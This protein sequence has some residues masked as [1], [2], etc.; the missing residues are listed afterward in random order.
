[1]AAQWR[2]YL[3]RTCSIILLVCLPA[4]LQA[5]IPP[6]REYIRLGGRV[7]AIEN[8][9]A[10]ISPTTATLQADASSPTALTITTSS[11]AEWKV[12]AKPD[13]LTADPSNGS[14]VSS[15]SDFTSTLNISAQKNTLS[16]SRSYTLTIE[17]GG[18]VLSVPVTQLGLTAVSLAPQSVN[19][20]SSGASGT[21]QVSGPSGVQWTASASDSAIITALSPSFGTGPSPTT[22]S[23]TV[24]ANLLTMQRPASITIS[25]PNNPQAGTF[26]ITEAGASTLVSLLPTSASPA[27]TG[28]AASFT[29]T[30]DSSIRW[31]AISQSAW[32]TVT[33]PSGTASGTGTVNYSVA[34]NTGTARAGSIK[35]SAA[36]GGPSF[37][38]VPFGI[39][40][41][42]I[43]SVTVDRSSISTKSRDTV[44][45]VNVMAN[46]AWVASATPAAT[47]IHLT[48]ASGDGSTP[49]QPLTFT[50]ENY[51]SGPVRSATITVQA[52]TATATISV[53]QSPAQS[54]AVQPNN[55]VV[56]TGTLFPFSAVVD[57]SVDSAAPVNWSV[58]PPSL[59]QI[60]ATGMFTA[61]AGGPPYPTGTVQA[62]MGTLSA[63]ANVIVIPVAQ[64]PPV[65]S[66]FSQSSTIGTGGMFSASLTASAGYSQIDHLRVRVGTYSVP[67]SADCTVDFFPDT[68][69][70]TNG[71]VWVWT[72][73]SP[74]GIAYIPAAPGT[75]PI[76]GAYCSVN[77]LNTSMTGVTSNGMT[78][79][80][81]VAFTNVF[82]GAKGLYVQ[83][84]G[85]GFSSAN[86]E[87]NE[88]WYTVIG[89]P[90][91][92]SVSP[93]SG[94]GASP[95]FTA[96]FSYAAGASNLQSAD[97]LLNT[98][99]TPAAACW[100]QYR[101]AEN[102]LY[103]MGDDG[104]TWVG[105]F[106][107]N[108]AFTL[109][110]SQCT[111]RG[112]GSSAVVSG[113]NLTLVVPIT[114]KAAFVGAKG[115]WTNATDT[116]GVQAG[117]PQVGMWTAEAPPMTTL[118]TSPTG[119]A[120]VVDEATCTSPCQRQW[121][122]GSSHT[123]S[124]ATQAGASGTQYV[125][126]NWSDAGAALHSITVPATSNTYTA[127]FNTQYYLT[128]AA[129]PTAGGTISPASGWYNAG[130][131]V[132]VS[133]AAN[134]GFDFSGFTADLTGTTTPQTVTMNAPHP[135]TATFTQLFVSVALSPNTVS[136]S[137]NQTQQFT[138]T[139]A[140]TSNTAV[141]WR[142]SP[143]VGSISASGLY[144]APASNATQQMV[145]VTATSVAD[146]T[147]SA[148]STV[149]LT[150]V[151]ISISPTVATLYTSGTQQFTA[152]VTSSSN[153][154]VTWSI[155][156]AVGSVSAAGLYTAPSSIASQQTV[157]VTATSNADPSKTASAT[158]TVKL[159]VSVSL[160]PSSVAYNCMQNPQL[161][162]TVANTGN[163]AV[164]W[165]ASGYPI[166]FS[167]TTANTATLAGYCMA[168][169]NTGTATATSQAD[170][171]KAA[172]AS[173]SLYG[174]TSPYYA[175]GYAGNTV[176]F[177]T[178]AAVSYATASPNI[179]T[180]T[181]TPWTNVV[182]YRAPSVGGLTRVTLTVYGMSGQI[183]QA[184]IDCH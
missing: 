115:I 167:G 13:W 180:I 10:S 130:A 100:V 121:A 172:S 171:S 136:R 42:I 74:S 95:A 21:F 165:S 144:T 96:Q 166:Y 114:F 52:S 153:T 119:L 170:P 110:N 5:Q 93:N 89:A 53:T 83:T 109:E 38:D 113:N 81:P 88:G 160:S 47:W 43:P 80:L 62:T 65:V 143:N 123:I 2:A 63:S 68:T 173:V 48:R 24:A 107:P 45:T 128:T 11:A 31:T 169:S 133:A 182:Q 105:A 87:V 174:S 72:G 131:V 142:I 132:P 32:I 177:Y 56:T 46:T 78:A 58:S 30:A 19:V 4:V 79:N 6:A 84:Q 162:A 25:L 71:Q 9:T 36:P 152:T 176:T 150:V 145:T 112:T 140:G 1:M 179:G 41:G 44:Q 86:P 127:M 147:K 148:S 184:T 51:Y 26:T 16:N 141:T 183:W 70:T 103:L 61:G 37:T 85:R 137:I 14:T 151:G 22:V 175:N 157:T 117:W 104:R 122:A 181:V 64:A 163:T 35:I 54:L 108:T 7:I 50:V 134:N 125:F 39:N 40:Q 94:N 156:P 59:G 67:S 92:T 178:S 149:T 159:P 69:T 102:K 154:A 155:N 126:S 60:T 15:G 116:N 73:G 111:L 8:F 66:G 28:G 124:A 17:T 76:G 90:A 82:Q 101:V 168:N 138:A 18:I 97:I 57:G 161:T 12:T 75:A 3:R 158:V 118:T 98:I 129:T 33:S 91:A 99:D 55:A 146:T 120:L 139:V 135:V 20:G 27:A 49:A 77:L 23:Y 34:A 106:N 29:V 164:T